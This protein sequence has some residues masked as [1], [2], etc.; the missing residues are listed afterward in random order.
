MKFSID[1]VPSNL[2]LGQRLRLQRSAK[3][4]ELIVGLEIP[5]NNV[6][7]KIATGKMF[8]PL[9]F[10]CKCTPN[11]VYIDLKRSLS[12]PTLGQCKFD[13]SQCQRRRNSVKMY[14]IRLVLMGQGCL[15]YFVVTLDQQG[16]STNH[17]DATF[18]FF[19]V[20]YSEKLMTSF[21]HLP[22]S[23]VLR[24]V[25]ENLWHIWNPN[26]ILSKKHVLLCKNFDLKIWPFFTWPWP[27]L[28]QKSGW[29]TS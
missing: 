8:T 4:N 18:C 21:F 5:T 7:T 15:C 19:F 24:I 1:K 23:E 6:R 20:I 12:N 16:T 22:F 17:T 10:F 29:M 28:R 25:E 11:C 3:F 14:I 9:C 2:T 26:E 13:L 27:D